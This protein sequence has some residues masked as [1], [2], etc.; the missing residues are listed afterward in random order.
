MGEGSA[1]SD[2]FN[3]SNRDATNLT[4]TASPHLASR[5]LETG[6][7]VLDELVP[8]GEGGLGLGGLGDGLGGLHGLEGRRG[9]HVALLGPRG[10]GG[11]HRTVLQV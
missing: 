2:I 9:E 1:A 4:R 11:L 8:R 6:K 10:E 7:P 5:F 3:T